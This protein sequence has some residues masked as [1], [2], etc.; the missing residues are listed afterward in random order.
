MKTIAGYFKNNS[1]PGRGVLI[2]AT[3]EGKPAIAYFI[4]GRSENSK[5]RVF[6]AEGNALRTKAFDPAKVKDPS[7]II[8][9]PVR[10]FEGSTIVTNGDQTDTIY[11]QLKSGGTFEDALLKRSFEP[12]APNYTPRISGILYPSGAYKLSV[13]KTE[14]NDPS[15]P[16]RAFYQYDG[17]MSGTAH[18]I[19]TYSGDGDPL[20]SFNGEPVRVAVQSNIDAFALEIWNA[21]NPEFRVSLFVR[22]FERDGTGETRIINVNG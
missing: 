16:L 10:E 7:L 17:A 19:H 8:Y 15:R 2:G 3:P 11:D 13:L 5:N 4:M 14:C 12:D 22:F 21:L 18:I 9:Y 20:P 6:V 1:Y